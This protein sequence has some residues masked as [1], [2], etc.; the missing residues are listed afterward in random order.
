[1]NRASLARRAGLTLIE[2]IVVLVI[3]VALAGI[4]VVALPS[5]LGRAHTATSATNTAEV[6]KFVQ[7]YEQLYFGY[8]IDMD[9]LVNGA[10][11]PDYLPAD[12]GGALG[13]N[14]TSHTLTAAQRDALASAGITRLQNLYDTRANLEAAGGTPTFN[15]YDGTAV[16]LT[17]GTPSVSRISEAVIEGNDGIVS[18]AGGVNGDV[19]VLFGF[20]KRCSMVG[21]VATEPP[22]HF[23][24]SPTENASNSYARIAMVFRVTRGGAT[25]V[26][27]ERAVFLGAVTIH[28]DG[29]RGGGPEI[30]EY[31]NITR[32]Q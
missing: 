25:P 9:N 22:V 13:G 12:G 17:T 14:L 4:L 26:D 28:P 23:T 6:T 15:P 30:E 3:L 29:I 31:Y 18:D 19:Y 16:D 21:K 8:P 2:L 11:A 24:D 1:M 5:M 20:G 27:L 7:V 10:T 32:A